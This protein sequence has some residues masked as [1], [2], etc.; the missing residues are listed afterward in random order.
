[1]IITG[2]TAALKTAIKPAILYQAAMNEMDIAVTNVS[3][4][5]SIMYIYWVIG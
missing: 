5:N 1:M 4:A 3:M 2:M